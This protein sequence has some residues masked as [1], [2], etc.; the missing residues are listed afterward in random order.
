VLVHF[1][2]ERG[3]WIAGPRLGFVLVDCKARFGKLFD[4]D[5]PSFIS[6]SGRDY[7][8]NVVEVSEDVRVWAEGAQSDL[9]C[10]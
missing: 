5:E 4:D 8:H 9:D 1:W 3:V 2:R 10:L 6:V 7:H